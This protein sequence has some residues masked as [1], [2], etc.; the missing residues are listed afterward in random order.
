[1][2]RIRCC[3]PWAY[4]AIF[5]MYALASRWRGRGRRRRR[6]RGWGRGRPWGRG[7]RGR[8]WSR[9]RPC[10][11]LCVIDRRH[12]AGERFTSSR[13]D[14]ASGRGEAAAARARRAQLEADSK[15][16]KL[17]GIV[18]GAA[19]GCIE[20][21]GN[22]A[23]PPGVSPL[24]PYGRLDQPSDVSILCTARVGSSGVA[25]GGDDELREGM[26]IDIHRL[27]RLSHHLGN[28]I[29]LRLRRCTGSMVR[30]RARR[31][32]RAALCPVSIPIAVEVDTAAAAPRVDPHV[33]AVHA[34]SGR[35]IAEAIRVGHGHQHHLGSSQ[36]TWLLPDSLDQML[37]LVDPRHASDPLAGMDVVGHKDSRTSSNV[38]LAAEAHNLHVTSLQGSS[39]S[40]EGGYATRRLHKS[41][42]LRRL[43]IRIA[44][45]RVEGRGRTQS[46]CEGD[47]GAAGLAPVGA[48][49]GAHDSGHV[50]FLQLRSHLLAAYDFDIVAILRIL[51][52]VVQDGAARRLQLREDA[53]GLLR[54]AWLQVQ[55][56]HPIIHA[57]AILGLFTLE[58]DLL[59]PSKT[60]A[61]R[62]GG[63][64]CQ[65]APA[66]RDSHH[67]SQWRHNTKENTN[68]YASNPL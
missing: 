27:R 53:A 38:A 41:L 58:S 7:R 1:M 11:R 12:D 17:V 66:T 8:R 18:D 39:D 22:G 33:L 64:D 43:C 19:G 34:R 45:S 52:V 10:S 59:P 31:A 60:C 15:C 16:A 47:G 21:L 67:W 5:L 23:L 29:G 57:V 24:T 62:A 37:D 40:F 44:V 42:H 63:N 30:V 61:Q 51:E 49:I 3:A 46:P 20:H 2:L 4:S 13:E 6:C 65:G 26:D 50:P 9:G 14:V 32:G 56:W 35:R 48:G 55:Q 54:C 28:H 25:V 36:V 68:V